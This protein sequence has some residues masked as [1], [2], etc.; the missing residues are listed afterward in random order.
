MRDLAPDIVRQRLLID[1]AN[2]AVE[3]TRSYFAAAAIESRGF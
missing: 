2:A 3:F 1:G